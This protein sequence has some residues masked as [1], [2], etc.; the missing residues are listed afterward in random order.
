MTNTKHHKGNNLM[1]GDISSAGNIKMS[2][3]KVP[4]NVLALDSGS[5]VNILIKDGYITNMKTAKKHVTIHYR[6]KS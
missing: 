3:G 4:L 5:L 2:Q 6:G 1:P